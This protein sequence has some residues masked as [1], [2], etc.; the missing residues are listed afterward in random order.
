MQHFDFR[1]Y[2]SDMEMGGGG[3]GRG[4]LMRGRGRGGRGGG[5]GRHDSRFNAGNRTTKPSSAQDA[6]VS[7]PHLPFKL[8][9]YPP[10]LPPKYP[11]PSKNRDRKYQQP[12]NESK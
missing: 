12:R 4:G 2:N 8:S 10:L 9:A 6:P 7:T 1:G 11:Y 3:R 5:G